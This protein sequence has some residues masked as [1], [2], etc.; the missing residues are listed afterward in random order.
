MAPRRKLL[1]AAV[2]AV[3]VVAAGL[4]FAPAAN[5]DT[6][7]ATRAFDSS[8]AFTGGEVTVTIDARD[9]GPFARVSE[10]LPDGW[11]YT[12]SSLPDVAVAVEGS[13][14]RFILLEDGEFT[15][16]VTAPNSVGTFAFS[17]VIENSD[18]QATTVEGAHEITV[19]IDEVRAGIEMHD[20]L[21]SE[22]QILLNAY[23]C[24]FEVDTQFV[25]GG[26]VDG[27]PA[28]RPEGVP[29]SAGIPGIADAME[30]LVAAQELLL[31]AYRCQLDADIEL[32]SGGLC[33]WGAF[34]RPA[35]DSPSS[36]EIFTVTNALEGVVAAQDVLLSAY[37][38]WFGTYLGVVLDECSVPDE[39]SE[40]D[41]ADEPDESDESDESDDSDEP[42]DS[43][44]SDDSDEADD[45]AQ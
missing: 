31:N 35:A 24:G 7:S 36:H 39:P 26:C 20:R 16:T 30:A 21:I 19:R 37:R 45:P 33:F 13:V 3:A 11:E 40:S 38:C 12:G 25:A 42:D 29:V 2:A 41:E 6:H 8:E 17:G 32:V 9:F 10:T 23:R 34:V 28:Q 15:Y 1:A 5:A 22:Q 27:M 44:E 14:V 4:V 18:R 43:V